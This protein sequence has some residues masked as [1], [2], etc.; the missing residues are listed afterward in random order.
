M[1]I[2]KHSNA[3]LSIDHFLENKTFLQEYLIHV[4]VIKNC[5]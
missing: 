5:W 1:S 2:L 3:S 4:H